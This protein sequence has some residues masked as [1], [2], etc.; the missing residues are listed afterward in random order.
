MARKKKFHGLGG[1]PE[2]HRE[3][4]EFDYQDG[5]I[6]FRDAMDALSGSKP[7]C[8]KALSDYSMGMEYFGSYQ[9]NYVDGR[10]AENVEGAL[11]LKH[12][13]TL[14]KKT[15]SSFQKACLLPPR[16]S[17]L[18]GARRRRSRR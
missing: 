1:T 11:Q 18:S 4:A 7:A 3:Q 13:N 8:F 9:T 5:S 10:L 14:R 2:K 15:L 6:S 16:L 12:L 17:G